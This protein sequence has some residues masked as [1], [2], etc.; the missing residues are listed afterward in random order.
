MKNQPP[1]GYT[2]SH[3]RGAGWTWSRRFPVDDGLPNSASGFRSRRECF[4]AC[5]EAAKAER[6]AKLDAAP[7]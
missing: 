5:C 7:A 4:L 2:I 1:S 3:R 6:A